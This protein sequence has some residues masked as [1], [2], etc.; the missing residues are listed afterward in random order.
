M[1]EDADAPFQIMPAISHLLPSGRED[2]KKIAPLQC[3]FAQGD[4][5]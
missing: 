2:E 5:E 4:M 3:F 1:L